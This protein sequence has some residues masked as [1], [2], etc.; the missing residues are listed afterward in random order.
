MAWVLEGKSKR[1]S[2]SPGLLGV[3][4]TRE[5]AGGPQDWHSLEPG[6][7][8]GWL[9]ARLCCSAADRL[10]H[11]VHPRR[12]ETHGD[13]LLTPSPSPRASVLKDF[14]LAPV[15][16]GYCQASFRRQ[17]LLKGLE[18]PE[19][20]Q[21]GFSHFPPASGVSAALLKRAVVTQRSPAWTYSQRDGSM[22]SPGPTCGIFTDSWTLPLREDELDKGHPKAQGLLFTSWFFSRL[23]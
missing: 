13:S 9:N 5:K 2:H 17:W 4:K 19:S 1:K 21:L 3:L 22:L 7:C 12:R 23:T 14:S 15:L 18:T 16:I 10:C 8:L 6:P 20:H 11:H